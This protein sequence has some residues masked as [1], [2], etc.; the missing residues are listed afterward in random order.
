[1][2]NA[3]P[4]TGLH[5]ICPGLCQPLG[6]KQTIPCHLSCPLLRNLIHGY[7]VITHR[8]H[9]LNGEQRAASW[10]V[11]PNRFLFSRLEPMT[12]YLQGAAK[13]THLQQFSGS[14]SLRG[15]QLLLFKSDDVPFFYTNLDQILFFSL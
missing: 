11:Q 2:F 14:K 10:R 5:I 12:E 3:A 13:D 4:S 8:P 1:M 6:H 15:S 7:D 9:R